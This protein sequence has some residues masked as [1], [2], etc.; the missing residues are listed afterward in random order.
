MANLVCGAAGKNFFAAM[1]H[2]AQGRLSRVSEKRAK[3]AVSIA[4]SGSGTNKAAEAMDKAL[5]QKQKTLETLC[6]LLEGLQ[7]AHEKLCDS[8]AKDAAPKF[9]ANG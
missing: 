5:E 8:A 4:A 1:L 6:K 2:D 3:L 9:S 7:N